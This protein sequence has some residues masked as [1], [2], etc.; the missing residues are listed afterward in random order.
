[1]SFK[2]PS[3][4]K[5]KL[6]IKEYSGAQIDLLDE[7]LDQIILSLQQ[8]EEVEDLVQIESVH[9]QLKKTAEL[10]MTVG[11]ILNAVDLKDPITGESTTIRFTDDNALSTAFN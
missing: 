1:M 10:N 6:G 3:L 8:L 2:P 11:R 7:E 4:Q 5:E 9:E